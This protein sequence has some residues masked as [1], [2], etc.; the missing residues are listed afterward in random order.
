M[1]G[2][3]FLLLLTSFVISRSFVINSRIIKSRKVTTTFMLDE[4][5]NK[6]SSGLA[7]IISPNSATSKVESLTSIYDV[8]K[9]SY[10]DG[11]GVS[12][13]IAGQGII[14]CIALTGGL[15]FGIDVLKGMN[16]NSFYDVYRLKDALILTGS[17]LAGAWLFDTIPMDML[18]KANRETK[19]ALL[20]LFGLNSSPLTVFAVITFISGVCSFGE[21]VFYR[22]FLLTFLSNLLTPP[23]AIAASS[24]LFGIFHFPRGVNSLGQMGL[25]AV[26]AAATFFSG[27]LVVPIVAHTM[28]DFFTTGTILHY[29]QHHIIFIII[30]KFSFSALYRT[31]RC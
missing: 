27:S 17:L 5:D 7:S 13:I 22:G 10:I 29:Y 8:I 23:V 19:F 11:E 16:F 4:R 2:L 15:L 3:V 21:E 6:V 12:A 20:N 30:T 9:P 28:F 1:K 18:K 25:G 26:Y 31:T 24:I 14:L